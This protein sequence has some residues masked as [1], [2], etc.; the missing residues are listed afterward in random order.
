M[1]GPLFLVTYRIV[2]FAAR[3]LPRERGAGIKAPWALHFAATSDGGLDDDFAEEL[4][5]LAR[6]TPGLLD[7]VEQGITGSGIFAARKR[8]VITSV[9][10]ALATGAESLF[11]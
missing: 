8:L 1:F 9:R 7:R 4:F 3:L 2:A 11:G 10:G 5:Q 6:Q